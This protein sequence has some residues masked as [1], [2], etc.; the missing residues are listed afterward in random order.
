[1]H[2]DAYEQWRV[3]PMKT[4]VKIFS[5]LFFIAQVHA[6]AEMIQGEIVSLNPT[7][8]TLTLMTKD[9]DKKEV[10]IVVT[11]VTQF[12]GL[13]SL[14]ELTAGDEVVVNAEKSEEDKKIWTAQSV[15]IDKVK[16]GKASEALDQES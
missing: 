1:M 7:A 11:A 3:C 14:N 8:N 6:Y 2:F 5:I 10:N 15:K 12:E 4:T 9:K 13:S 16:I